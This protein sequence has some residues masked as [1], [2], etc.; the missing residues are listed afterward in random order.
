MT[1]GTRQ[2]GQ[3]GDALGQAANAQSQMAIDAQNLANQTRVND[4]LNQL[5]TQQQDLMYNPQTGVQAQTGLK[6][7]Q[8]DSGMSLADEYTGKLTDSA[9]QISSGLANPVQQR[10][11]QEQA[12]GI[13]SQ[14]HGATTQWEGQQFK[15]YALST[16]DGTIKLATNQIGLYYNDPDAIDANL[17]TIKAA[18]YQAGQI[19]GSA[20]TEIEANQRTM[21]SNALSAAVDTAL[22]QG[23]ITYANG[24]VQKYGKDMTADDML[25]ING[26]MNSFL[27][28][29]AASNVVARVFAQ[30]GPALSNSPFDKMVSITAASESGGKENNA[31]GSTVTSAKGAQ[32]V[33][34]VMPTT[35]T[36]PG[37]GVKPAQDN[38]P[39]ERARVGRDYLQAMLAHYGG[40]PS[41]AWAAYNAGPGTLDAA[42]Q[43]ANAAGAPGNWLTYMPKE[44]QNYV[45]TNVAALQQNN[46]AQRPSKLDVINAVRADPVLQQKPEWMQHA[47]TQ[48]GQQYDE[49]TEAIKQQD[50]SNLAGVFRTLAS[51]R[52]NINAVSPADLAK[53]NP[54]DLPKVMSYAKQMNEGVN[55][56]NTALYQTYITSP[57]IMSKMSNDQWQTQAPNFSEGDFKHL[58][59]IRADLINGTGTN[60]PNSLNTGAMTQTLNQRLTMIGINPSP[61]LTGLSKDVEG[62]ERVGAIRQFVTNSILDA[63]KEAGKKFSES[64][65]TDHID[66]LF[67]KSLTFRNQLVI[68]PL[69]FQRAD[70]TVN[71]MQMTKDQIPDDV[72][73]LLKSDFAKR[74]VPNPTNG[75]LL[76]AYWTMKTMSQKLS[77]N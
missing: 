37:F 55:T 10:L 30:A 19:N 70:S 5:K 18:V 11:F 75:Q 17:K 45:Q 61:S 16:Q 3:L 63:Q 14:F 13:T 31:D 66:G 25:K 73:P 41:K 33:M 62:A 67:T 43:K 54:D 9:A 50:A 77:S 4:A 20:A 68:G 49:Q 12:A 51:N 65:I 72:L 2:I 27:G 52:G 76:G 56:T 7:I 23:Q 28:A 74:G 48:A 58:T 32:G 24:L 1:Q 15:S 47:V 57:N 60:S 69:S 36:D 40:D 22:Q 38:S 44:T 46:T 42:M 6:A 53:V 59:Q 64:E 21:T 34:Q 29:Q 35:N 71:M 26:K 8:R 39:G